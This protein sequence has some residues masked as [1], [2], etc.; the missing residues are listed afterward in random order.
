MELMILI[1]IFL[2][3][4]TFYM[5]LTSYRFQIFWRKTKTKKDFISLFIPQVK[6]KFLDQGYFATSHPVISNKDFSKLKLSGKLNYTRCYN[7]VTFKTKDSNWEVFFYL[8]KEDN[9]FK[10]VLA[11]RAFPKDIQIKS[12]ATIE[13]A[14]DR[15]NVL[16]NNKYLAQVLESYESKEL[17]RWI[18]KNTDDTFYVYNNNVLYKSVQKENNIISTTRALEIVKGIHNLKNRIYVKGLV[19]Y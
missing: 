7:V 3:S 17:L 13:K 6:G 11:I 5:F 18:L 8:I 14:T 19:E 12:Q 9:K 4:L 15:V 16:A 10:E 2:F 1:V